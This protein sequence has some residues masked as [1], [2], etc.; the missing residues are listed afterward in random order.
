MAVRFTGMVN[1]GSDKV[2]GTEV[3]LKDSPQNDSPPVPES[4]TF[5]LLGS[6]LI[7][8]G[9]QHCR[10]QKSSRSNIPTAQHDNPVKSMSTLQGYLLLAFAYSASAT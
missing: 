6:R 1:G 7:A 3:E 5:M 9:I 10:G 2:T 8:A 4:V